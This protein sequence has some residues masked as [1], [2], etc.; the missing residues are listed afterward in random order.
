MDFKNLIDQLKPE[1]EKKIA[2]I[3]KVGDG[4]IS[5]IE[6]DQFK[7]PVFHHAEIIIAY[8]WDKN[9]VYYNLDQ[10]SF[11]NAKT[12][13]LARSHPCEYTVLSLLVLSGL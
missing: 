9:A 10:F 11:P 12:I 8:D 13:E 1:N 7:R 2:F 6:N 3:K 4:R 5:I